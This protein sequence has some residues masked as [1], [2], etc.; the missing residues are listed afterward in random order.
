[1]GKSCPWR[2]EKCAL[3]NFVLTSLPYASTSSLSMQMD[4]QKMG[5]CIVYGKFEKNW[6]QQ[7]FQTFVQKYFAFHFESRLSNVKVHHQQPFTTVECHWKVFFYFVKLLNFSYLNAIL[8]Q[9]VD[10]KK[11]RWSSDEKSILPCVPALLSI[12]ISNLM[13]FCIFGCELRKFKL[14]VV[15]SFGYQMYLLPK[16]SHLHFRLSE[17]YFFFS[18]QIRLVEHE[19]SWNIFANTP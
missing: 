7:L 9:C 16:V 10:V 19:H 15:N 13:I 4:K 14:Y 2:W 1:M 8:F 3:K 11:F 18:H 12:N 17:A 6:K 5:S